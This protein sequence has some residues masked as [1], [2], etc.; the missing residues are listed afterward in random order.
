[1]LHRS[2]YNSAKS[3]LGDTPNLG[4][5]AEL[6]RLR[7]SWT[8]HTFAIKLQ[9][10]KIMQKIF[11]VVILISLLALTGC[12][13]SSPTDM[14]LSDPDK[15][16]TI[17]AGTLSANPSPTALST[18]TV[19]P[20][21]TSTPEPGSEIQWIVFHDPNLQVTFEYPEGWSLTPS[22]APELGSPT[23]VVSPTDSNGKSYSIN[24]GQ[25]ANETINPDENLLEWTTARD[26]NDGMIDPKDRVISS[27]ESLKISGLEA[28]YT[29]MTFPEIRYTDIRRDNKV[30]FIW[31]NIGLSADTIYQN[32]YSHIVT[33][34][35]S[36]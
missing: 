36:D 14:P 33:S 21:A 34:F 26:Q 18:S 27:R 25:Y 15:I 1:M 17:V 8:I 22:T 9:E 32:V 13:N 2:G 19:A 28:V 35:V 30:L 10:K 11:F 24:I 4:S 23:I 31:A 3:S 20:A 6:F 12:A 5:Q 7:R 29:V 16:A